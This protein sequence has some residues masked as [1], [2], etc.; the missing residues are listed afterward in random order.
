M[1]ESLVKYLWSNE[2]FEEDSVVCPWCG[3]IEEY[4][5]DE[6]GTYDDCECEQ[7]GKTFTVLPLKL[8]AS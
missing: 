6:Q 5:G 2:Q 1:D 7:C 4:F 3:H 8:I